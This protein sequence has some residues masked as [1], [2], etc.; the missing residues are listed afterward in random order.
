MPLAILALIKHL[1]L[2]AV[3]G[4]RPHALPFPLSFL[5]SLDSLLQ[6]P[7]SLTAHFSRLTPSSPS[8]QPQSPAPP[9]PAIQPPDHQTTHR[10][11]R[12]SFTLALEAEGWSL[13]R[14]RSGGKR[15]L[16]EVCSRDPS[17][18]DTPCALQ[19]GRKTTPPRTSRVFWKKIL[20][21]T[22]GPNSPPPDTSP[23]A[24]APS[25]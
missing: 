11:G 10:Q 23:R 13:P 15:L 21:R 6:S 12:C 20:M 25:H 7:S 22:R 2:R 4:P 5:T 18:Q 9:L 24:P 16:A 3:H 8:S 17:P 14:T 19:T 1:A